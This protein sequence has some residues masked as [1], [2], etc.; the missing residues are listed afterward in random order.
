MA[1]NFAEVKTENIFLPKGALPTIHQDG[2][3]MQAEDYIIQNYLGTGN[4]NFERSYHFIKKDKILHV[5]VH[6]SERNWKYRWDGFPKQESTY[7][8]RFKIDYSRGA[9]PFSLLYHKPI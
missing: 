1:I 9:D 4:V 6:N 5:R 2:R 8:Y 3:D 7:Y